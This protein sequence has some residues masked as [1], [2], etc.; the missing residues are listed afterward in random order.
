MPV[1]A[2]LPISQAIAQLR[3]EI[4]RAM[5][6]AESEDIQFK[7]E[8]VE[9]TLQLVA[10][11]DTKLNAGAGVWQVVTVD[12]SVDRGTERTHQVTLVLKPTNSKDSAITD[13]VVGDRHDWQIR[14]PG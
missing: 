5:R 10:T 13:I 14:S 2:T 11:T 4:T 1:K 3:D 7:L 6:Q 9:L 12:G 8:S